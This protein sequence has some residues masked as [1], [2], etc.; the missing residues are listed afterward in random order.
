ML[1]KLEYA[2]IG[3]RYQFVAI[4]HTNVCPFYNDIENQIHQYLRVVAQTWNT[5]YKKISN[6]R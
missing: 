2:D 3:C 4:P 5:P 6:F 1:L